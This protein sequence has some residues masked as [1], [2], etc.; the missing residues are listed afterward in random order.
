MIVELTFL[1]FGMIMI[2]SALL[3]KLANAG[4]LVTNTLLII[5]VISFFISSI[6]YFISEG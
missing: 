1:I 6:I 4:K 2:V 3:N 5:G